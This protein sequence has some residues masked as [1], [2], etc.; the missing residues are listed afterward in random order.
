MAV[1]GV[2]AVRCS[3]NDKEDLLEGV[4]NIGRR[5]TVDG[6]QNRL[7]VHIFDFNKDIY[8]QTLDVQLVSKIRDEKKFADVDQL[9]KQIS[10]DVGTA[11]KIFRKVK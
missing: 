9:Q 10:I 8:A 5:P 11:R 4:A 7:E 6:K 2:F 3:L 1:Q